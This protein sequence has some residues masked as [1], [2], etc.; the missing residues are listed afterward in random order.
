MMDGIDFL[1][2][3]IGLFGSAR[4][5]P[6]P[7]RRQGAPL[8]KGRY[9]LRD[10]MPSAADWA[11]SSWA[12]ARGTVLGFLV[13]VLPGAGPTV[14]SFLSYTVEKKISKHPRG[15][16]Q[17]R[18]RRRRRRRSRANNAAATARDG[19]DAHARHPRLGDHRDHARR[20]DDVGP[21][22]RA[23]AVREEPGVRLGPD[24]L[25]VHRQRDAADPQHRV[26]PALRARAARAL[27]HPDAAD[28]R[29]SASPAR[30][31]S[32]TACGTSARCWSSACSATR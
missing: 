31:R 28:H 20:P 14:A 32:R 8:S 17:R 21:A 29:R 27:R 15:V 22:A 6:V 7:S 25:A 3:A 5:W 1:P 4:C 13:G 2:V 23:D 30:T 11:R 18:D 9:G 24:R 12:I 16:R 10:V 19:A 26:H